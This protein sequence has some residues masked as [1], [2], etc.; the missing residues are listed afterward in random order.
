[1]YRGWNEYV[2]IA[3]GSKGTHG[4]VIPKDKRLRRAKITVC[5]AT[6][7]LSIQQ[8]WFRTSANFATCKLISV[9]HR[10]EIQLPYIMNQATGYH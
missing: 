9:R 7:S 10:K 8:K 3:Y 5:Q 4:P 6:W 2:E 1:M